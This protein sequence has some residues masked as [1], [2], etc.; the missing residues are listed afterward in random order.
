MSDIALEKIDDKLIF[1]DDKK[2]KTNNNE[3]PF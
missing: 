2:D 1:H 3:I